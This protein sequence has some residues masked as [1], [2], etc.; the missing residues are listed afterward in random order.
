[1]M[2][3]IGPANVMIPKLKMADSIT[4][5]HH[6]NI[7]EL[8]NEDDHETLA[9]TVGSRIYCRCLEIRV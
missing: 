3:K 9:I 5:K 1:M 8:A 7:Y 2:G 6:E 4:F